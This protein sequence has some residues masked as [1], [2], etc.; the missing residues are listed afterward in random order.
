MKKGEEIM[1][2]LKIEKDR[3]WY[4]LDDKEWKEIDKIDKDDLMRL[5]DLAISNESF[6]IDDFNQEKLANQAQS[7]IYSNIYKKFSELLNNKTRFKDESES[8]YK[9]ALDKYSKKIQQ[10]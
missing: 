3:G 5:L 10:K 2:C 4:T 8:M 1:K 6:E 9:E 7:I